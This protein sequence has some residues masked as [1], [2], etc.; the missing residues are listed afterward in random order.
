MR[1]LRSEFFRW[2]LLSLAVA[3]FGV[4][5]ILRVPSTDA[6]TV[7]DVAGFGFRLDGQ[8]CYLTVTYKVRGTS[9]RF[10]SPRGQE[11]CGYEP[12]YRRDGSVVVYYDSSDPGTA[13]LTPRGATPMV[14]VV[15][16]LV[17]AAACC[18]LRLGRPRRRTVLP[19]ATT[20]TATTTR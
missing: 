17:T 14:A 20:V 8:Q 1:I 16:G 3:A 2:L 12:L 19:H 10:Q 5:G 9:Y 6:S 15:L 13:T 11:W 4:V 7:G 18:V